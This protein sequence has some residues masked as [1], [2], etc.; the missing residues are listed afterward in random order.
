MADPAR[1]RI[2]E[3]WFKDLKF[4]VCGLPGEL[5]ALFRDTLARMEA[6]DW[7]G[8]E[9]TGD[10]LL[11]FV[12]HAHGLTEHEETARCAQL[13]ERGKSI[14]DDLRSIEDLNALFDASS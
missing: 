8:A 9:S 1:E 3:W 7:R 2:R 6:E 13:T 11:L 12:L 5:L 4:C 10:W 14:L